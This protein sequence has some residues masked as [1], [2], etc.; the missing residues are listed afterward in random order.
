MNHPSNRLRSARWR[1]IVV[2]D[3]LKKYC[4]EDEETYPSLDA[5]ELLHY[6]L[7]NQFESGANREVVIEIILAGLACRWKAVISGSP[8]GLKAGDLMEYGIFSGLLVDLGSSITHE[9]LMNPPATKAE[10]E[11][12]AL[13][14]A[15]DEFTRIGRPYGSGT[16]FEELGELGRL[17]GDLNFSKQWFDKAT[18]QYKTF[19]N[20]EDIQRVE[21][22]IKGDGQIFSGWFGH[23]E[24]FNHLGNDAFRSGTIAGCVRY[25][26]L[27]QFLK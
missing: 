27:F 3:T 21:T 11:Y 20:S 19:G 14:K 26:K 15:A 22:R 2:S 1:Q 18:N 5:T 23:R 8:C 12:W 7:W 17:H 10:P 6:A 24:E 16:C 25:E 13:I 4:D 9:K